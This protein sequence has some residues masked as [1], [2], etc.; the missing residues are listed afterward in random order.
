MRINEVY[1]SVLQRKNG[2]A[3]TLI[4]ELTK[5]I[6]SENR[7]P[8]LYTDLLN[9]AS[10]KAYKNVGFIECGKVNQISFEK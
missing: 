6:Y 2:Y 9:P 3:G 1:T 8:M 5:I 10:N 4:S 7:I